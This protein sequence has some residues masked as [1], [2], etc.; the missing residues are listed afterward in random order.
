MTKDSMYLVKR[1]LVKIK[2]AVIQKIIKSGLTQTAQMLNLNLKWRETSL[3]EIKMI[4]R[5]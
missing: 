3:I 5:A 1:M 4:I 2:T